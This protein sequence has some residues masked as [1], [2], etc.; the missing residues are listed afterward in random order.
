MSAA[1]GVHPAT[2]YIGAE[3]TGMDLSKPL[4]VEDVK[5]VEEALYQ[6][7]VVY[8]RDQDLDHAAHLAFVKNF[9]EP[10][11]SFVFGS[12]RGPDGVADETPD[13]VLTLNAAEDY[14]EEDEDLHTD[15]TPLINPPAATVLRAAVIPPYGGDTQWNNTAA[16]Y[17]GLSPAI[18][19]FVNGLRAVH[20]FRPR[21]TPKKGNYNDAI[22][23]KAIESIH[24]VVRVHPAS[25]ERVLF[26]NPMFTRSIVGLSRKESARILD[27]LYEQIDTPSYTLRF[28]WQP[29][30]V[31]FFDNRATA[32][33]VPTDMA[34]L[35]FERIIHRITMV[36]DVP[37]GIDGI[38]SESVHGEPFLALAN[39]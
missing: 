18:K 29:G 39:V 26:V 10:A 14:G 3:I 36:G 16:A 31:V 9:G 30:S 19:E 32:H 7:K 2:P 37:R 38:E 11:P 4:S 24:P 35:G 27:L 28:R 23:S 17:E 21:V 15:S 13:Y 1:V 33:R 8:F 25:G 22:A 20:T 34:Q 12:P 6:W 5:V